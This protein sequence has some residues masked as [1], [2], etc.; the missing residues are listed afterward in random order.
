MQTDSR[1]Y[2]KF[3]KVNIMEFIGIKW[4]AATGV[5]YGSGGKRILLIIII[6]GL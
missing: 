1:K 5:L 2:N 3:S 4:Y 6:K